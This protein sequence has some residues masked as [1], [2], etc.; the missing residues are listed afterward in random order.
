MDAPGEPQAPL[1]RNPTPPI[2]PVLQIPT[3]LQPPQP[4]V[5]APGSENISQDTQERAEDSD[6]SES[7]H[8]HDSESESG[9]EDAGAAPWS[10]INEDTTEPGEDEIVYIKRNAGFEP[11]ATDDEYWQ[12]MIFF[13]LNDPD[14][15]PIEAGTIDWMLE[16]Y[17]GTAENPNHET[18]MRSPIVKVG[19]YDWRI[20]FYPKGHRSEYLSVYLENV[21][22]QSPEWEG[23]EDFVNPP[24]PFLKGQ[25]RIK[26]RRSVAAQLCIIMYN[27]AEPRVFEYQAEAHQFHKKSA[28]YGWR[29]FT[30]YSRYDFHIRQHGQRQAIL[31]N[32]RLAFRAYIRVVDD[33]TGC[34]WE[35]GDPSPDMITSTTGLRP[36]TK[37]LTYIAAAVPLLHF[38]PFREW[39]KTLRGDKETRKYLQGL[40]L[41]MYTRKRSAN[42]GR[43]ST[44]FPGDVLE[45]LWRLS[46]RISDDFEGTEEPSKFKELVGGFHPEKGSAC[47]ANRL[48][49]KDHSSLQAAV[50][51]HTKV[52]VITCPPLLTLEL[53]RQEHDKKTRL[54]KKLVN[55]VEIPDHL[56]V[57]GVTYTLFAFITHCGPLS[58]SR[59][60]PYVRPRGIGKGWYAYHDGRVT[61]L[62]ETEARGKHSGF[63]ER[64]RQPSPGSGYDSPFSQY[65]EH[66]DA[67]VTCAVM[68]VRDDVTPQ[69]FNFPD[70]EE[71]AT[72]HANKDDY[73]NPVKTAMHEYFDQSQL[74]AAFQSN[75]TTISLEPGRPFAQANL[76][77]LQASN[78]ALAPPLPQMDGEDVVMTDADDD[79][80]F[81]A[82]EEGI[83]EPTDLSKGTHDW[84][85]QH[86]Y[87]GDYNEARHQ[88]GGGHLIDVNGD[89]YLGQFD[90]GKK[91]GHGKIFYAAS[92]QQYEGDWLDDLPHGHGKL[93]EASGNVYEGEFRE[94]RKT[95]Q[96][97]LR[98][99]VTEEDKGQC[100][101]C[102][103]NEITTAFYDCGHV[104]ACRDC[105]VKIEICPVCRK[106]VLHKLQLYGVKV[107]VD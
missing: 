73:D 19:G 87:E 56:T 2:P 86:Y 37:S 41:K 6:R 64:F 107:Q 54:W 46:S 30:K 29:Y 32:D 102:F 82:I 44:Q 93:T 31:R 60:V 83:T 79:S 68:Y 3:G 48:A 12:K 84:L 18:V 17:N 25:E 81:A 11:S 69:A 98:G 16:H 7:D 10:A 59:Y 1:A 62:T 94:G 14:L 9:S 4:Q 76:P 26:K 88:H 13:E 91:A 38:Q 95:G 24:F 105:A 20:K 45:M 70:T 23:T 53:Q 28:D 5:Q 101:I 58:S 8:D 55:K 49:T 36:F 65:N 57:S 71:W 63:K 34:K 42:F 89:E 97:V 85:G 104:I 52:K 51:E 50:D 90:D 21:T 61:I 33:P 39:V 80:Q 103:E 15:V 96:F 66:I 47:G 77:A 27:P 75:D 43:P 78:V 100:T 22:I 92:G 74:P 40:L 106:R 67:E 35:H 72:P 99:T